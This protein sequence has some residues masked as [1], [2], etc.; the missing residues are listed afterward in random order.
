MESI[1]TGLPQIM[2]SNY[3]DAGYTSAQDMFDH[4]ALSEDEQLKGFTNFVT[5][6]PACL[7]ALQKDTPDWFTF[8]AIYNTGGKATRPE[9]KK[10]AEN[11]ARQMAARATEY[12]A[13][14]QAGGGE[15]TGLEQ[16]EQSDFADQ[17]A[18]KYSLVTGYWMLTPL[19]CPVMKKMLLN[20]ICI[21]LRRCVWQTRVRH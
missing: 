3:A 10:K 15:P 18:R 4:F 12:A 21:K 16:K 17:I 5:K 6:N 2:G 8:A 9:Q 14:M 19:I 11:Y 13:A 7:S 1:S 20:R